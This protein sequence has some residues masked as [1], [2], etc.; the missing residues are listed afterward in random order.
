MALHFNAF[1]DTLSIA[2]YSTG[3]AFGVGMG[4]LRLKPA[5][6]RYSVRDQQAD[7][8]EFM[9]ERRQS[10]KQNREAARWSSNHETL[11]KHTST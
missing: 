3:A 7:I 1:V 8:P 5:R 10:Y 9:P 4:R 2:T 11:L 6:G